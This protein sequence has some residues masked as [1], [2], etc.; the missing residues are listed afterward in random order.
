M[1]AGCTPQWIEFAFP[2]K[3]FGKEK[4]GLSAQVYCDHPTGELKGKKG[5]IENAGIS[6]AF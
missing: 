1:K 4:K 6:K 3:I 2:R 5:H